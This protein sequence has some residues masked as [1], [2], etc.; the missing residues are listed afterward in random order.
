[1]R[2]LLHRRSF[3]L[4]LLIIMSLVSVIP[5]VLLGSSSYLVANMTLQREFTRE[6]R[7]MVNQIQSRI[8][9]KLKMLSKQAI[10]QTMNPIYDNFLI[11]KDPPLDFIGY[12]E[13][14]DTIYSFQMLYDDIDGIYLY[15]A[16]DGYLVYSTK[17][18]RGF[19]AGVSQLD[20]KVRAAVETNPKP[21]F[22]M[23]RSNPD[24]TL[25]VTLVRNVPLFSNHPNGYFILDINENYIFKALSDMQITPDSDFF[26]VTPS[27][28]IF[29]RGQ[30]NILQ[31]DPAYYPYAY[32][33]IKSILD[34]GGGNGVFGARANGEDV[35]VSYVVSPYN[36]WKYVTVASVA[37][38]REDFLPILR[39]TWAICGALAA[40]GLLSAAVL[41][42]RFGKVV[43]NI[44]DGIRRG[45]SPARPDSQAGDELNMIRQYIESLQI[46][47]DVLRLESDKSKPLL[48]E[49]F[50][51]R[52]ITEQMGAEEI[53]EWM[54]LLGICVNSDCFGALCVRVGRQA[55]FSAEDEGLL[56]FAVMNIAE[57]ISSEQGGFAVFKAGK[58]YI[59]ILVSQP[60]A[61][62]RQSRIIHMAEEIHCAAADLLRVNVAIGVGRT[63]VGTDNI[64]ASYCES[65]EALSYQLTDGSAPVFLFRQSG[66][67]PEPGR[68]GYPVVAE[69][70][71]LN[72]VRIGSADDIGRLLSNYI[73]DL[74]KSGIKSHDLYLQAFYQLIAASLR[75]AY[76]GGSGEYELFDYN[77]YK[78]LNDM[79]TFEMI[80]D[81]LKTEFFPVIISSVAKHREIWGKSAV[82]KALSYINS[83]YTE[84]LSQVIL[85]EHVG[86]NVSQFGKMFKDEVGLSFGEY[87]ISY[88]LEKAKDMLANSRMKISE[89]AE[90]LTYSN[91]QNFIRVFKHNTGVTPAEYRERYGKCGENQPLQ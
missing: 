88:R 21:Y 77:V 41:S 8:D 72:A 30:Q 34:S 37:S 51:Q 60:E 54:K 20:E 67:E 83:H 42:R 25:E 39:N 17:G 85:A 13:V 70:S 48:R 45:N 46:D 52:L 78:R 33:F 38:L 29:A 6:N 91:S 16:G 1:M 87:V 10:Q 44:V 84:D 73:S 58:D 11:G 43:K 82:S 40:L 3:N 55:D 24:G 69:Q 61:F 86:L 32:P 14:I 76:E 75:I 15:F 18:G 89:I 64:R 12:R 74:R 63:Y 31:G 59:A 7:E 90:R 66:N 50:L 36:G 53:G 57:E 22:W 81:W 65:V 28:N 35:I 62:N 26:I 79:Y 68:A 71:V 49:F 27:A 5:V 23:E 47:Y 19:T 2:N 80:A 56:R 9:D 4:R